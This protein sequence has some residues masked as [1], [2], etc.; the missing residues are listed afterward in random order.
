LDYSKKTKE[1]LI[2]EIELLKLKDQNVSFILNKIN[3]VFYKVSID[4][5]NAK[6]I[7]YLSP[8]VENVFGLTNEEYLANQDKL[9][10][11]FHPTDLENLKKIVVLNKED[12]LPQTLVY[13]FYNK[14]KKKYTWIEETLVNSFDKKNNRIGIFGT[15]KDVSEKKEAENQLSFILENIS[16]CIYNVKFTE[17]EKK[18]TYISTQIEQLL[19]LTIEEFNSEGKKGVLHKRIHPDDIAKIGENIQNGLYKNKQKIINSSFR[20]KPKGKKEYIWVDETIHAKYDEKGNV[21]ETTTVMRDI[22]EKR[23]FEESITLSEK[24]Y[25]D[26]F[27][28]SP[29]LLYIQNEKGIFLDVNQTVLDIYGLKKKDVIGKTPD[30]FSLPNKNNHLNIDKLIKDAWK[31]K[32]QHFEWWGYTKD[33]KEFLEE[34]ILKKA[35][36]FNQDVLIAVGRDVTQKKIIEKHLKQNEE[37]Y[38]QLFTKNMAGVFITENNV[39][40][41][42]NNSFAKMYGYKSRMDL[43]GRKAQD[44]YFTEEER[45]KYVNDL[46]KKGYLSN[47]RLRNKDIH[48]N[49]VWILTN[50]TLNEIIEKGKEPIK[51]IEG[52]LIDITEQVNKE[53]QLIQS[54]E[55]YKNL[56]ENSPYGVIIHENGRLLFANQKASEIIGYN[57]KKHQLKIKD[58]LDFLLPEYREDG[59]IRREKLKKGEE[60]PFVD[61]RVKSPFNGKTID[62]QTRAL[63]IE[64]Q[65]KRATQ[66]VFQ[67]VSAQKELA[68]ERL[69]NQIAEES[70]KLLQKEIE[71]RKKIEQE[72]LN[73]Q[74]YTNNIISSS[75]DVISSADESGKVK[76]FNK[77]AEITFGYTKKEIENIDPSE[78]YADKESFNRV[79]DS[80]KKT[81]AFTGEVQNKR[82]NGEIFTSFLSA[83]VLYNNEGKPIG[84][85]G[86][87]RDITSFKLAEQELVESEERYRDLFENASDLIQSVAID[88]SISYVNN[89]WKDTLGYSDKDIAGKSIFDFL[90]P[91]GKQHCLA[92]FN[93]IV[94]SNSNKTHQL[95]IDLLHKNGSKINV[96]GSVG[97]K[98]DTNGKTVST[99]GIFRNVTEERWVKTRQEVYNNVSKIISEKTN[100]EEIYEAIRLELSNVM[101]TDVFVVSYLEKEESIIF[102]F[103]YDKERGGRILI[104][105]RKLGNGVN[106]Y[107]LKQK[108]ATILKKNQLTKLIEEGKIVTTG[109]VCEVFVGVPLKV[110][111]N[112]VGVLSVQ[113][114]YNDKEY[115][116][117]TLE[118]LE[119]ISGA[120]ALTAKKKHDEQLLF[121]Q[122]AKLTSIIENSSHLFWTYD[123]NL[124]LTSFNQNYSDA[125]FD[126]YGFRPKI[127]PNTMSRVEKKELQP[128]WNQKYEE[129]FSG[130]KVEFITERIN[131][132]GNRVIREVYLNP[133]FKENNEVVLVSG[134]AH[135][136]T[137]K[138]IAEENL[139]DSLKEK[140]VL[141]KEVHHR[142]KNN[143]QVISSILNLQSSYLEDEKII[144]ILRESQDRIKTMSIIHES[145]YQANDFSQINFSQY[146]VSL[147]KNLVHSYGNFD[148]FVETTY[149]IDDV[150]LSL[151]LSIP[152]GLII[153]ELISNALKY[154]FKGREKGKLNISLQLKN[155]VVTIIVADNGVGIPKNINIRETNSLGLQLVM[156]L[157]EQIDGE[158]KMDNKKGTTFTIT[159][160]QIQ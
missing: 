69:K 140:E 102:P 154:A 129:A 104:E 40:I 105:K 130:K 118:F 7:E 45:E 156:S 96:E 109:R 25:K 107:F 158:L 95:S 117:K 49:E 157:V 101:N 60:V 31:G 70:N 23:R 125:V 16:E 17:K 55:K 15:A 150:H 54:E 141:L 148:S 34:V 98:H 116:D 30:I 22:T 2:K 147:S 6:T 90:H 113:S 83:S 143:L 149:E 62:L 50:V 127:E 135:D 121:E 110:D 73:N 79:V 100:A 142:V 119:F 11:Y 84:T 126:L 43:M 58:V 81:G 24:S 5:N 146:V 32:P 103:S 41:E 160:K 99:R 92:F 114:D 136:I 132:K 3:E 111:N 8:Q 74:N 33:G 64:F 152:C 88:G 87:S 27:N 78:L 115:D 123:K 52:T 51:R 66:I 67:D 75:L 134:I 139:R 68:K 86:V 94:K 46:S 85:M 44:L 124:G 61:V 39:V 59:L 9:F 144:N 53:K 37:R 91:D 93:D 128:F 20:F 71:E 65:N 159:F 29:D 4:K 38:R 1:E 82:K 35:T 145:L 153:N 137:D 26:L 97:G 18:L 57:P 77:A 122:T 131:T 47:Y 72:L 21:L 133:I 14:K 151:D 56:I 42:C 63:P 12:K 120:I 48:G 19:G 76:E 13:R 138:Q 10:E 112:V 106:E 80:L 108:K 89:A 155:G 36:Y 28:I